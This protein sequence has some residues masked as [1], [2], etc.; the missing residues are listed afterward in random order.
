MLATRPMALS[1]IGVISALSSDQ[2]LIGLILSRCSNIW[3]GSVAISGTMDWAV[4]WSR[5]L[6]AA[7]RWM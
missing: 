5:M 6:A 1:F 3:S 4:L 2:K 7:A